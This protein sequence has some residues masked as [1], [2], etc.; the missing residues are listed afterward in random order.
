MGR[1]TKGKVIDAR[2][3]L[4]RSPRLKTISFLLY[5]SAATH[6][7]GTNR[8]SKSSLHAAVACMHS[9]MILTFMYMG[10]T[11]LSGRACTSTFESSHVPLME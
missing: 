3:E 8:L 6:R 7:K 1:N 2:T 9:S 10:F 11:R 4:P 5:T